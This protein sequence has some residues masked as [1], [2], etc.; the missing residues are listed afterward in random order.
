VILL[1]SHFTSFFI[2]GMQFLTF[3]I[4]IDW[5]KWKYPFILLTTVG[6]LY[7][8]YVFTFLGR[9]GNVSSDGTWV[10]PP[11]WGEIYGGINLMLNSKWLVMV[12]LL[13]SVGL[14]LITKGASITSVYKKMSSDRPFQI[15]LFWFLIPYLSMFFISI[16]WIPMFIERYLLYLTP[17]LFI[18][19]GVVINEMHQTVRF[20]WAV[21]ATI[22]VGSIATTQFNPTNGRNISSAVKYVKGMKSDS[23]KVFVCP[24]HFR[25]A[26]CY[27]YNRNVFNDVN[28]QMS[29][30][31]MAVL[32]NKL[33]ADGIYPV[34]DITRSMVSDSKSII[35]FDADAAFT[36]PLNKNI[37]TILTQHNQVDSAHFEEI[38]NVYRFEKR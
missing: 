35:Y 29:S 9:L 16:F 21:I 36:L 17:A 3:L 4:F 7:S 28:P 6:I 12:L 2:I 20:K 31:P 19:V 1:Y 32:D 8:P 23:S 37:E 34:M 5:K 11:G 26:F 18:I 38:F 10:L 15:I 14:A 13:I 22:F 24:E 33:Q 27:H 25:L 30:D